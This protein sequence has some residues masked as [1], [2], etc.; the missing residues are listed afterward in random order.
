MKNVL[1][2]IITFYIFSSQ[3]LFAQNNEFGTEKEAREILDRAVNLVKSNKTVAFAMITAGGRGGL[4]VKD[5]YPFCTSLNGI[6][7]AHPYVAGD[8][9]KNFTSSDGKKLFSIMVKNAKEGKISKV[10]YKFGRPS[11]TTLSIKEYFKTVFYTRVGN[12]ICGSG[13]YSN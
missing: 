6:Q 13:F 12:Y 8:D 3:N 10:S 2:I 5:L 11:G 1:F 7:V 9:M 4:A